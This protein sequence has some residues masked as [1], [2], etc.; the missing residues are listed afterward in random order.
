MRGEHFDHFG[1]LLVRH[2]TE[3]HPDSIREELFQERGKRADR[4]NI[5]FAIQQKGRGTVKAFEPA[6]PDS[7]FNAVADLMR[8]KTET[9]GG[10]N[11][12]HRIAD[13]MSAREFRS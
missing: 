3:D 11:G 10:S 9:F 12:N 1:I 8:I 7:V 5:V 6:W 4:V 13:L 2:R